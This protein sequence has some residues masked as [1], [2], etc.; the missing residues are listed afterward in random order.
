VAGE[1]AE[2]SAWRLV[3]TRVDEDTARAAMR[4]IYAVQ[5]PIL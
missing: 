1:G 5:G 2:A 3:R 4:G